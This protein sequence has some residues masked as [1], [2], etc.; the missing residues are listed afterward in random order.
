MSD[1]DLNFLGDNGIYDSLGVLN[2]FRKFS[3]MY[4]S[5]LVEDGKW[6]TICHK[7]DERQ[8]DIMRIENKYGT[9]LGS[10]IADVF[11][12]GTYRS[13]IYKYLLMNFLCYI[14]VPT[15]SF[16][17]DTG[18][19]KNTFNKMLATSNVEVIAKWLG[20]EVDEV[21]DKYSSR[22]FGID[23]DDGDDLLPYVKLT[24][25]KEGIRKVS[26]PR[27]NIDVSERGTRVIPLFM[28]KAGVDA[29]HSKIKEDIVKVSFLKDGGQIRDMFITTNMPKIREIYGG[30]SFYEDCVYESYDGDFLLN[31]Y[32]S[33]GF[34][35]APEI[36]ASRYD[37]PVRSISYAR[38]IGLEYGV[39]PDLSFIN[40]DMSTVLQ[41]FTDG[42]TNNKNSSKDIIDML[43]AFGIDGGCWKSTVESSKKYSSKDISSLIQWSEER[44]LLYSTVF[45]RELCLFM[46]ANPQWFSN[47]TGE[48]INRFD[49]NTGDIGLL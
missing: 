41:G 49:G 32:L 13:S 16:K 14:E 2:G 22:V 9:K 27:M 46:L 15:T 31:R 39:E 5:Q 10:M 3:E 48:P 7:I 47:F 19:F 44:N 6:F 38:I 40:I 4:I 26:V 8:E 34:I 24:E 20:V 12:E 37:N 11:E 29:L 25:S 18:S 43:E 42:V 23:M 17:T 30:G 28:L 33:R 21:P 1:V 45:L 35:K 36:G